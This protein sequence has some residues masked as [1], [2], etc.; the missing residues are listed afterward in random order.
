MASGVFLLYLAP[1][2]IS[3]RF[4][5]ISQPV[6]SLLMYLVYQVIINLARIRLQSLQSSRMS[7]NKRGD[8]E[9]TNV[10]SVKGF[11]FHCTLGE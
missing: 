5:F 9:H 10:Y 11:D 4:D 3:P 7:E 6:E 1:P 8:S 2:L